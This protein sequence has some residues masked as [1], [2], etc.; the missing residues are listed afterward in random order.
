MF[1]SPLLL[2]V[3]PI[4]FIGQGKGGLHICSL[5]REHNVRVKETVSPLV[6]V[7][8]CAD[9]S[10]CAIACSASEFAGELVVRVGEGSPCV[11]IIYPLLPTPTFCLRGP[12]ADLLYR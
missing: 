10:S 6:K 9:I 2:E 1:S 11:T 3:D 5:G 7:L 8:S 12:T 4:P